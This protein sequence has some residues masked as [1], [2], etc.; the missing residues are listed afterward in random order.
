[1]S[2]PL[3]ELQGAGVVLLTAG[4]LK[5]GG[6]A[7]GGVVAGVR[8]GELVVELRHV[9]HDEEL[10]RALAPHHVVSVQQLRDPQLLLGQGEGQ[11]TVPETKFAIACYSST[12]VPVQIS[13]LQI[14]IL[15]NYNIRGAKHHY[16]T[17][18]STGG[19]GLRLHFLRGAI[20]ASV[21]R[22]R[23]R[24]EAEAEAEAHHRASVSPNSD[25]VPA[26]AV[27]AIEVATIM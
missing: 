1:M 14:P 5:R 3:S 20:L 12:D 8:D 19:H 4:V 26:S 6:Q 27:P 7:G 22:V 10:V 9:G 17:P 15:A 18:Q 23:V 13:I 25:P 21:Y 11:Q 24:A 2:H 16:A